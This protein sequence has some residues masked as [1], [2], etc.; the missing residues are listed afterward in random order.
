[1]PERERQGSVVG[2]RRRGPVVAVQ[3]DAPD[4]GRAVAAR[5]LQQRTRRGVELDVEEVLRL[6]HQA[7]EVLAAQR[8]RA[9]H[10]VRRARLERQAQLGGLVAEGGAGQDGEVEHLQ[11]GV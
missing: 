9:Q 1:Q 3:V 2:R 6:L 11:V 7:E 10:V 5:Q 4:A 8:R